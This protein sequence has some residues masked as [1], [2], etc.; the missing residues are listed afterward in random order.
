MRE[1]LKLLGSMKTMAILMLIF[2]VAIGYATFIE[3]D[4]GTMTAK[5]EVYN[6]LWFEMLLLL[7]AGNLMYNIIQYKMYQKQKFLVFLFHV[8]FLVI[9]IGAAVTRYVGYEGIMHIREGETSNTMVS[10][11]SYIG[12]SVTQKGSVTTSEEPILLSKY[13]KNHFEMT[14]GGI[15][16][17]LVDYIP[18]A[19]YVLVDD[20]Q[21][22]AILN[23][24]ITNDKVPTR[25]QL[26]EGSFFESSDLV[27]D[28][29][30]GNRFDKETIHI[31][32]EN[33][34]LQMS[35]PMALHYLQMDDQ[36]SG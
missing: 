3:N 22:K 35:H 11:D 29:N 24:M 17:K 9:L 6:A 32:I 25:V 16:V 4:Y 2:A 7:L 21:G 33:N 30:S 19:V 13:S 27:I 31:H 12:V 34:Q 10:S 36:L 8:S 23:M 14:V 28:F 26:E 20:P 1:I 15:D 18:N 5:A